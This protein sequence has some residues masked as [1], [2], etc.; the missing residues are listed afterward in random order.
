MSNSSI[1]TFL[2]L[3]FCFTCNSQ[4]EVNPSDFFEKSY[5][6]QKRNGLLKDK[7]HFDEIKNIYS[8][9]YYHIAFNGPDNWETDNGTTDN[10]IYRTYDPK[11]GITF[12]IGVMERKSKWEDKTTWDFHNRDRLALTQKMKNQM[13]R[14]LKTEIFDLVFDKTFIKNNVSTKASSSFTMKNLDNEYLYKSIQHQV[15]IEKLLFTFALQLP[16]VVYKSDINFYNNLFSKIT[17][18]P[19]D[20][21]IFNSMID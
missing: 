20:Q 19:N 16:M 7:E 1:I 2:S 18:L 11:Y 9:Y 15:Y 6:E 12:S 8:N 17:F 13:Q 10:I 5:K 14:A 3:I 21:R 4:G